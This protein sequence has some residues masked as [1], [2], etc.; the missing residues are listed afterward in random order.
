M[1]S[2]KG[3]F[4]NTKIKAVFLDDE[5]QG[6][7]FEDFKGDSKGELKRVCKD[8]LKGV[9]H[10]RVERLKADFYGWGEWSLY[11]QVAK[12]TI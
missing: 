5:L 6:V 9:L 2:L 7:F 10:S 12:R 1:T 4:I 11:G 8:E 3:V